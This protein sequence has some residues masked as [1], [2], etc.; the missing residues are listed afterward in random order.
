MK[1]FGTIFCILLLVQFSLT[2]MEAENLSPESIHVLTIE[3]P[4]CEHSEHSEDFCSP[5]C[6]CIC[7]GMNLEIN[8]NSF[9]SLLIQESINKLTYRDGIISFSQRPTTPPPR[10]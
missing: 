7:C 4:C 9:T 10:S 3:S 5:L 1:L 6:S 8:N 2:C